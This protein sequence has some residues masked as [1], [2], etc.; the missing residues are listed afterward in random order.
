MNR[1]CIILAIFLLAVSIWDIGSNTYNLFLFSNFDGF[2]Y[3]AASYYVFL[4]ILVILIAVKKDFSKKKIRIVLSLFSI[5]CLYSIIC[6][7]AYWNSDHW[8]LSFCPLV[9]V[10]LFTM[11]TTLIMCFC[12]VYKKYIKL[13]DFLA[14]F[15]II[16][17]F[18]G[19]LYYIQYI[20][21][22]FLIHHIIY[23]VILGFIFLTIYPTEGYTKVFSYNTSGSELARK[24]IISV[25]SILAIILIIN[26]IYSKFNIINFYDLQLSGIVVSVTVFSFTI[27]FIIF[28]INKINDIDV[29]NQEY[30]DKTL[31][32]KETL[33]VEV[34]HRVKNNMQIIISLLHMEERKVQDEIA[35]KSLIDSQNRIKAMALIH[36]NLY[37]SFE[38]ETMDMQNYIREVVDGIVGNYSTD[39]IDFE[40]DIS[41]LK[42]DLSV[43]MP[44][45]LIINELIT[46]SIKYAFPNGEKG[47]ISVDLFKEDNDENEYVLE[48][49][50]NGVGCDSNAL[51]NSKGIGTVL[52]DSLVQ[53]IEGELEVSFN[54]GMTKIIR[55]NVQKE[56]YK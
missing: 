27:F 37:K 3:F 45:G 53:Q 28:Y 47:I 24:L 17:G 55:F 18:S 31:D 10:G 8:I 23:H 4:S 14:L 44:L 7:F 56:D 5:V 19:I 25:P 15:H 29:I 52:V 21:L 50:D 13:V 20:N 36:E 26:T 49:A 6:S 42:L 46:N 51:N 32:E 30:L 2:D 43:A 38:F 48:I 22:M 39:N 1:A 54:E 16:L 35:K 34:H 41:D 12:V 40:L 11:V 33:L 9:Q